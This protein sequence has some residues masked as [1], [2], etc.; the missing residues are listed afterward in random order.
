MANKKFDA[1]SEGTRRSSRVVAT[2]V[3]PVAAKAASTTKKAVAAVKAPTKRAKAEVE[4]EDEGESE[5]EEEEK[6][7]PKKV[8]AQF[9]CVLVVFKISGSLICVHG[10]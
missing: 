9:L 3:A 10:V 1:P 2:P 6:P 5:D 4:S 7:K 8:C